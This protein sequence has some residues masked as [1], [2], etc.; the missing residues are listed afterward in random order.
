MEK[1]TKQEEEV[2]RC[3]WHLGSCCVK[4][5]LQEMNEPKP[6]YTTLAS[7]VKNLERKAYVK[8]QQKGNTYYY[9]PRVKERDYKRNFMSCFVSNYF[10]NSYKEMVPFF[11]HEQKISAEELKEILR[12]IE[13][14]NKE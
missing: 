7:V 6:P 2:M 5:I 10:A 12:S 4:E 11:A 3:I 13:E 8:P 1:L 14:G 9:T